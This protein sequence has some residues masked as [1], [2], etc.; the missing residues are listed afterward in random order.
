MP[1]QHPHADTWSRLLNVF[2]S[3]AAF[4]FVACAVRVPFSIVAKEGDV[5]KARGVP[6]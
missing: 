5:K 4:S 3:C 6:A 2:G 1:P